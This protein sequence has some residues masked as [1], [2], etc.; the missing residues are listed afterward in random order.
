VVDD[1]E[2]CC[3]PEIYFCFRQSPNHWYCADVGARP[4]SE[5]MDPKFSRCHWFVEFSGFESCNN[6]VM[7]TV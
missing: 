3:P 6:C 5:D 1:W 7:S 2:V 4:V